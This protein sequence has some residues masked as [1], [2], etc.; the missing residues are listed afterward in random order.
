MRMLKSALLVS[1]GIL[2]GV[3]ANAV[4]AQNNAPSYMVAEINVKDQTAYEA[5]GVVQL[6]E[7]IKAAGGKLIAGGYNKTEVLDGA[8]PPNR[9][10]IFQYPDKATAQKVW[11]SDIKPWQTSEKVRHVAEFR[12]WLVEAA[13][14]DMK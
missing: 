4:L 9:Y 2:I 5:S 13:A 1:A 7:Q 6:R 10:L 14:P 3:G 12:T 8:P 11:T